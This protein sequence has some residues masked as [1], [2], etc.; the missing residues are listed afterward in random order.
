MISYSKKLIVVNLT[1]IGITLLVLVIAVVVGLDYSFKN[2]VSNDF[3]KNPKD[4]AAVAFFFLGFVLALLEMGFLRKLDTFF[5][6]AILNL[7]NALAGNMGEKKTFERLNRMLGDDYKILRNFKIPGKKFDID[8]VIVGPKG[9][10]TFE[11]KNIGKKR[12]R[13]KFEG[14]N[15]FKIMRYRDGNECVCKMGKYGNQNPIKEA[16]RHNLFF[17]EW[18][19]KN[20]FEGVK[21]KGAVLMV[22]PAKIT[23]ITNPAVYIVRNLD[24]IKRFIDGIQPDSYFT[25]EF[26]SNLWNLLKK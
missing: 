17:E 2:I 20:N 6:K 4:L 16:L 15:M 23:K 3:L 8:I 13:F 24:E 18:L 7:K 26:C 22:G 19:M 1:K 14:E 25:K 12:D 10:I 9:I 21:V 5:D 11:I